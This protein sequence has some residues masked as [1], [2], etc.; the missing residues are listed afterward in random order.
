MNKKINSIEELKK[1]CSGETQEFFILLNFGLKSSKRIDWDG[2]TF[3]VYNCIDDTEQELT[4][5]QIMD[6]DYTNIGEAIQKKAFFWED[7]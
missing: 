6:K 5:A 4:E 7:N 2:E 3:F 1:V